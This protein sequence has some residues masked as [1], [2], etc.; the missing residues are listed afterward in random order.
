MLSVGDGVG[1]VGRKGGR[2]NARRV[3]SANLCDVIQ[4]ELSNNNSLTCGFVG[5]G[6][7]RSMC[8]PPCL[9]PHGGASQCKESHESY[10]NLSTI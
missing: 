2:L 4:L 6:E 5:R 1:W 9:S 8:P 10:T 7:R 3:V